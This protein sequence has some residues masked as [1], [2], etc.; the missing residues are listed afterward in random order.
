M[1]YIQ[2][3]TV[4]APRNAVRSVD[5]IYETG[6]SGWA[7]A[8]L[9]WNG[10]IVLGIRWNGGE[11]SSLGSPNARGIPTWF[12]LPKELE[13]V[14]RE[15]VEEL[16]HGKPGGLIEGYTQM[17]NDEPREREAEQW[18]EGLIGDASAEG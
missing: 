17:A 1:G 10:E 3:S 15:H 14:V 2:P 11:E 6:E 18:S 8:R 4:L 16:A 5:V 9:N 12:I 7:V 13:G